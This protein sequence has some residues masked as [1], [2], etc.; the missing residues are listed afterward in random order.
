MLPLSIPNPHKGENTFKYRRSV[1]GPEGQTT[2]LLNWDLPPTGQNRPRV[3]AVSYLNTAPLV[4][5]ML[6][7]RQRGL[8][9]VDFQIPAVC[10]D[11]LASGDADIGIVPSFE[12]TRQDLEIVRGAGIACRGPVRSILLLCSKPPTEVRTL[13]ADSSS[14]TSVQLARII[15]ARKFGVEPEVFRHAPDPESMLR[16]AD[17][18]LIIGDPA[19][20]V[21]PSA[22]RGQAYDL[23]AEWVAMTG[24]PMVFAVWA[25]R[26]AVVTGEIG[27]AFRDSCRYGREHMDEIVMEESP[28]RGFPRE[29]VREYLTR[30]IV[31]ELEDRDYR[32]MELFLRYARELAPLGATRAV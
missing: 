17:A 32:G 12:L 21:D 26:R 23:G 8:F 31:H 1:P 25:G 9:D 10:A 13:A 20:R 28:R 29:I 18:A 15:L 7:G 16:Q 6:H 3:C 19:L 27:E 14:R 4:W 2:P 30:N 22:W 11:Q 5:G 24:L